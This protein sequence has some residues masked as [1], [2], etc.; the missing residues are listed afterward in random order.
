MA[1]QTDG[2]THGQINGW[3]NTVDRGLQDT[4]Y[5]ESITCMCM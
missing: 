4:L 1:G 5:E 3:I 2:W